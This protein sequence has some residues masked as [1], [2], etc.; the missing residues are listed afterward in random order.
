MSNI[1]LVDLMYGDSG[2][3]RYVDYISQWAHTVVRTGGGANA[4]HTIIVDGKK[5]VLHLIP[6]GVL[7]SGVTCVLADGMVIDPEVL[8]Q[9]IEMLG[10]SPIKLMIS[11]H[12]HVVF[13]YHKELD[14]SRENAVKNPIGTTKRG[15]GPCYESKAARSGVR[16]ENYLDTP[17][18]EKLRP[19]VRDTS[20]YLWNATRADKNIL[21]EGA[22][23]TFLDIDHGTYPYVTSSSTVAGG[24]CTGSGLGPTC[25]DGVVG[26]T[27]A[28]TTR[29][30]NG[31]LPTE[32]FDEVGEQIRKV[33]KE[34]GATTGRDRRVGWLD[35]AALRVAC[36][37]NGVD[38]LAITKLD[39]LN[40]INPIK[41]C[42]GYKVNGEHRDEMPLNLNELE[43]AIPNYVGLAGFNC[44]FSK[45]KERRDLPAE[46]RNYLSF[47]EGEL[48]IP[49]E[50]ISLGPD[51][52][53]AIGGNP[54]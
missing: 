52:N 38:S 16:I 19:F 42:I 37:L 27:K 15:I 34:Y 4:G 17:L 5:I 53:E 6:S 31:P 50:F 3:G 26:I 35:A 36:R 8:V 11:P 21:F 41:V 39:V 18:G 49:I 10:F 33:G 7:R 32:L 45:V 1:I 43:L 25:M 23:G 47:I 2:K 24:A 54:F 9:E 29:V 22:Q 28:Y 46:A 13:P 12:A 20:R 48:Y 30:G 44:D 40:G 51:R 14:A